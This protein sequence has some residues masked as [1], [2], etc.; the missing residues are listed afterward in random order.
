MTRKIFCILLALAVI[1]FSAVS[2][3]EGSKVKDYSARLTG[4][5]KTKS[6]SG[7]NEYWRGL[8]AS[9]TYNPANNAFALFENELGQV[10]LVWGSGEKG[11]YVGEVIFSEDGNSILIMRGYDAILYV[12]Q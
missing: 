3:A 5:W 12:R 8:N 7:Y 6:S 11:A 9:F 10:F 2:F 1:S 4:T